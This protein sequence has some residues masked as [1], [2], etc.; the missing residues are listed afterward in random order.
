MYSPSFKYVCKVV[1]V[2]VP[3]FKCITECT[4]AS[5]NRLLY[6]RLP[7]LLNLSFPIIL[8]SQHGVANRFF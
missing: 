1:D 8:T 2:I 4:Q 3:L 6:L 5:G 7:L